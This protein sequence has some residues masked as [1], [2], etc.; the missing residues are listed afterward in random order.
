M[1]DSLQS[2]L[3]DNTQHSKETDIHTP[4]RIRT[5]KPSKRTVADPRAATGIGSFLHLATLKL[6]V[7]FVKLDFRHCL[8]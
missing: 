1:I 7:F 3:P 2:P 6:G 5:R 8:L 4:D